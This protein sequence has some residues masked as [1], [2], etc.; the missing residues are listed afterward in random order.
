[1]QTIIGISPENREVVAHELSK[2][3]ADEFVLY[4]KTLNAHWNLEGMDFH[5]VHVYFEE[6]Y[7]QSAEIVDGVA[8]RIRQLDHY[9]PATLKNFLQL[10]HL[11]EQNEGGNDSR[12]LIKQLL[13][14]H[15]SIIEFIRGTISEFQD[16]H[17]DAGTS[18][19]V[20]GLMETHEKIAWM[21]RAHLK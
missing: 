6:L 1:M 21:L 5:S 12:S 11:T 7:N 14:D 4:T 13:S 20:T 2:L 15:E 9:A 17:K 10:T 19:Y 18:D 8:E 3:L 16:A